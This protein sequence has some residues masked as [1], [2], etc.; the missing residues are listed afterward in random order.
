MHFWQVLWVT[1]T[2]Q[3]HAKNLFLRLLKVVLVMSSVPCVSVRHLMPG[4]IRY[5]IKH[6]LMHRIKIGEKL[7]F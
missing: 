2:G 4:A 7:N 3:E 6:L 5:A 1:D